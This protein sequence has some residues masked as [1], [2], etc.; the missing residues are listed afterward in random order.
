MVACR[1]RSDHRRSLRTMPVRI[2]SMRRLELEEEEDQGG[3]GNLVGATLG[4][5]REAWREVMREVRRRVLLG[6]TLRM[7][8]AR[9]R[10]SGSSEFVS[11]FSVE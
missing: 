4:V 2:C 5:M 7:R 1:R 11:R 6:R 10:S 3:R 9:R 8:V